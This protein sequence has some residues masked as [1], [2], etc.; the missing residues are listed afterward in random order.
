MFVGLRFGEDEVQRVLGSYGD[1]DACERG[2]MIFAVEIKMFLAILVW[3]PSLEGAVAKRVFAEAGKLIE[4]LLLVA[5]G[6]LV[7]FFR[8]PKESGQIH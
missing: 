8:R 1:R 3:Q 6:L 4:Q 5:G 2:P 7:L